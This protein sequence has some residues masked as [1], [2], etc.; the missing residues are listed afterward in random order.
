V[1][2]V[3][4][5]AIGR[6]FAQH[7]QVE[8][9]PPRAPFDSARGRASAH[10]GKR[11]TAQGARTK[12]AWTRKDAKPSNGCS[13][14]SPRLIARNCPR[15]NFPENHLHQWTDLHLRK[16][17]GVGGDLIGREAYF[18]ITGGDLRGSAAAPRAAQER[19]W[20]GAKRDQALF[21]IEGNVYYRA[22]VFQYFG[23]EGDVG[24]SGR[25]EMRR[26]IQ[27]RRANGWGDGSSRTPPAVGRSRRF[28]R[29]SMMSREDRRRVRNNHGAPELFEHLANDGHSG[30]VASSSAS[31]PEHFATSGQRSRVAS[32]PRGE[33]AGSVSRAQRGAVARCG[34][35]GLDGPRVAAC[36]S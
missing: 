9:S 34:C 21:A 13:N 2:P 26:R 22:V 16:F 10:Q 24:P 12:S 25:A 15:A 1:R 28:P 35:S 3:P 18:E 7:R 32:H 33:G 27:L 31:G 36:S 23:Q 5:R 17:L 4:K 8:P 14:T 30:I 20:I 29:S 19:Q 11:L 6:R